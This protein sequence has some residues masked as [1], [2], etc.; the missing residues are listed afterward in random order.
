LS[1]WSPTSPPFNGHEAADGE[2]ILKHAGKLGFEGVVSKTIDAP[3]APGTAAYDA[4][5]NRSPEMPPLLFQGVRV[6]R[7]Q[8]HYLDC[9]LTTDVRPEERHYGAHPQCRTK[10]QP[11][12]HGGRECAYHKRLLNGLTAYS[13]DWRGKS[14]S[15]ITDAN[16]L[17]AVET[18]LAAAARR[19]GKS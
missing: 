7:A 9:P 5:P 3:Y 17:A 16:A 14:I 18:R 10:S 4:K 15:G 6:D 2:L 8:L 11:S 13:D 19:N 12:N 1:R